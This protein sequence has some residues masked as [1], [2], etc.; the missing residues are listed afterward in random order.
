[1]KYIFAFLS[2]IK[3]MVSVLQTEHFIIHWPELCPEMPCNI[4]HIEYRLSRNPHCRCPVSKQQILIQSAKN[5]QKTYVIRVPDNAIT[6]RIEVTQHQHFRTRIFRPNPLQIGNI[7]FVHSKN[8][9]E[10]LK[11]L[12]FYL[13]GSRFGFK[14]EYCC[15]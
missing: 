9:V 7:V 11:M 8:V 3:S 12:A 15:G 2:H 6:F 13:F 4:A 5:N 1:M 14:I 10:L